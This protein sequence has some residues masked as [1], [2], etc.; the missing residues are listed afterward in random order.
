MLCPYFT[1][2][3]SA[4]KEF[5]SCL[6]FSHSISSKT[7]GLWSNVIFVSY[8]FSS[9][10]SS[11]M[12]YLFN[13]IHLKYVKQS[14]L[15]LVLDSIITSTSASLTT[16]KPLTVWITANWKI[17][18]QM[19]IPGHLICL[20]RN[21]Y[22]G[23]EQQLEPNV[24]QRTGSKLGKKNDRAVYCHTDYL[25][26]MQNTSREMSGWM[27]HKLESGLPGEISTTSDMQ[28]APSLWQKAKRN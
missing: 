24:E 21:L 12:C 26:H 3:K 10:F 14:S 17:N 11:F 6:Q 13:G 25:T 22:A 2:N 5:Q 7:E 1:R 15:C 27:S 18:K 4:E 28:T 9:L 16:R 8:L 23:Q 20:L 19:G